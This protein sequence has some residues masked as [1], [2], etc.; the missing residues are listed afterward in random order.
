MITTQLSQKRL[1]GNVTYLPAKYMIFIH[2]LIFPL[3]YQK[4]SKST[5][6]TKFLEPQIDS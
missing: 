4:T 2:L 5:I 3:K 6:V 1:V